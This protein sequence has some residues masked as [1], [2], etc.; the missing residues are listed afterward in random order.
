M[1]IPFQNLPLADRSR[2]W[3]GD[4]ARKRVREWAGGENVDLN[5]FG[6]AFL[7]SEDPRVGVTSYKLPIADIINGRLTAVPR[8][9][10]AAASVLQ[11]GRGGVDASESDIMGAKA[12]LNRYYAK[13]GLPS[14]FSEG[15]GSDDEEKR[16]RMAEAVEQYGA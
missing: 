14:P 10:F 6:R 4:A 16:R 2:P 15:G 3:D 9:I 1:V 7:I 11:G 13:M 12:H 8:G 5:Q